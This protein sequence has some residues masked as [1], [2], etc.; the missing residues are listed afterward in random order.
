MK[1]IISTLVL[2][3]LVVGFMS[4]SVLEKDQ[5]NEFCEIMTETFINKSF[6][7]I[8]ILGDRGSANEVQIKRFF[9]TY[10]ELMTT[11]EN[12]NASVLGIICNN[13]TKRISCSWNKSTSKTVSW[14]FTGEGNFMSFFQFS[15]G[16]SGSSTQEFSTSGSTELDPGET[17][18]ILLQ[19]V[20]CVIPCSVIE[21][22]V[23]NGVYKHINTYSGEKIIFTYKIVI[24][25]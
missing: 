10:P 1:K 19:P 17:L 7:N 5:E 11:E 18:D 6:E 22:E 24:Q 15:G 2:I 23:T 8:E 12:G 9:E 16:S 20:K 14:Y 25:N 4:A 21:Y 3:I 13:S